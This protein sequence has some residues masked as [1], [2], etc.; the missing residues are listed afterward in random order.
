MQPYLIEAFLPTTQSRLLVLNEKVFL[1]VQSLLF[2]QLTTYRFVRDTE[3]SLMG[4]G[5]SSVN[6]TPFRQLIRSARN[7]VVSS[8]LG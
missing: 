5:R 3:M 7:D 8:G 4:I 6:V 2:F 1:I